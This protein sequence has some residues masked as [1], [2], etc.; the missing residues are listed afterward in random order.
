MNDARIFPT[1]EI[2][3]AASLI[4]YYFGRQ[5]NESSREATFVCCPKLITIVVLFRT[6]YC[7]Q[8]KQNLRRACT[9]R[10]NLRPLF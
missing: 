4:H 7:L 6:Q 10:K 1:V 5:H 2:H 8:D 3:K 9:C